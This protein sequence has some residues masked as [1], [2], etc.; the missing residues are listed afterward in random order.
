MGEQQLENSSGIMSSFLYSL[1]Y[2][3]DDVHLPSPPIISM[4]EDIVILT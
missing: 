4:S 1:F 3:L 2:T